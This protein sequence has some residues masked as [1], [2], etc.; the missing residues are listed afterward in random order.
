MVDCVCYVADLVGTDHVGIGLD[1]T[2]QSLDG[3]A[4][5]DSRFW[6][7]SE[8]YGR[9]GP[10]RLAEPCQLPEITEMLLARGWAEADIRKL[11]GE[12]FLRVA[13]AVWK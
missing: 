13:R 9:G 10:M 12:N 8:G 3:L 2:P 11:L 1:Y 7:P 4:D 5:M 6:P